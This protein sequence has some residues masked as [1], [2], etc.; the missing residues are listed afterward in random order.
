MQT[1][2]ERIIRDIST[3]LSSARKREF[4]Y[5]ILHGGIVSIGVV[6]VVCVLAL[7]IE[8][9]F[10]LDVLPRTI[11]F[12]TITLI[13][14][15]LVCWGILIPALRYAGIISGEPESA[16]AVKVGKKFPQVRDHL[17]NVLQ[18][19]KGTEAS[20]FYSSEL[21]HASV[22]GLDEELRGLDF[23]QIVDA[24]PARRSVRIVGGIAAVSV[25]L[26]V[27]FP[28][29]F[30][31]SAHRLLNF[32]QSFAAPQPFSLVVEP[33]NRE[34]IKGESVHISARVIGEPQHHLVLAS[35][36]ADQTGVEEQALV[37]GD[38]GIFST[39]LTAL[40]ITTKYFIYAGDIRSDEYT[41]TV[42]ERPIIKTLRLTLTFPSYT[43]LGEREL[44][45]NAGDVSAL[46]GTKISLSLETSKPVTEAAIVF[47]DGQKLVLAT[48]GTKSSGTI[49]LMSD[50]KYRVHVQ[51]KEGLTNSEPIEYSL[52]VIPDAYPVATIL[53][54]GSNIDIAESEKLNMLFRIADDYGLSRLRLAHK[55]LQSRYERPVAEYSFVDIPLGSG[56]NERTM[57]YEWVLARLNLVPEDVVSYYIEVFDNDN[58]S[59]PKSGKSEVYT[60]RLPSMDEVFADLDKAHE[61]SLEGMKE[62]M[63]LAE[64][65]RRELEEL[66]QE[67]RKNQQKMTWQ[68]QKKAEELSKTYEQMQ[69]KLDNVQQT[70]DQMLSEMQKNELVSQETLEK[71]QELQRLMEEMNTPEIQEMMK[72]LQQAMQQMSPEAMKQ[73]MKDFKFSEENFRNSIE[74]TMNLLKRLQIEQKVDEVVKRAEEM[75]KEQEQLQE[76]TTESDPNNSRH[77]ED[78]ANQQKDLQKQMDDLSRELAELQEKMNEFPNEMPL[79]EMQK[80]LDEMEKSKLEELMKEIASQMQQGKKQEAMQGQQ[81]ATQKM[82]SMKQSLQNMQAAM[83]QNQQQQVVNAMR[84]AMQDLLE[85]SRRQEDLRNQSNQLE[86]NSQGFRDNAQDQMDVMRDLGRVTDALSRLSQRSFGISPELGK[87]IGDAMRRMDQALQSLEQRNGNQA[88]GEQSGAMSSLN[89]AAS[90]LQGAM[91][92]MMQSGGQGM[93]MAGFMQRLQKMSSMQQGINEGSRGLGGM[94]PQQAAEFGRLAGEQGMVRKSL[95]QLAREASQSGELSKMLGDLN[96]TAREMREVQTDLAQGN[97]NPETLRKQDRILSRLLDSQRSVRERDFEKKRRAEA[98]RDMQRPGPPRLDVTTQEGRNRLRSDLLKA[99]EEGY[100]RDYQE[101]IRKYFEALESTHPGN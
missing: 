88:G 15:V 66:Q 95:E 28:S 33:G 19:Y 91:N 85:L 76:K 39:D 21:I 13:G 99:M 64:E 37:A 89:E 50:R 80:T 10:F 74:R 29:M 71:Y 56:G 6:I 2:S 58:I 42:L 57:P 79:D 7:V 86:P 9:V 1:H 100:A 81:Q 44:D 20:R 18:L 62:A 82:G 23:H 14:I 61:V 24:S 78:L 36:P 46:R 70:V 98:G 30:T 17:L 12:W 32:S 53:I 65:A 45:E 59:G 84:R 63:Q 51:D 90:Q 73:A 52:R 41:L 11:L 54:P 5:A 96:K 72:K 68:E 67:L 16:T 22:T 26:F 97:V 27:V 34:V 25:L 75:M 93:G 38:G 83:K 60:L 94:T 40:K 101:L 55:L 49:T 77:R 87:S 8:G 48:Q 47:G 43:R 3:R 4:L 35:R 92:A 31:G 69:K